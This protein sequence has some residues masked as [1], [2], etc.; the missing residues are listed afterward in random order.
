MD[1]TWVSPVAGHP[2]MRSPRVRGH[3]GQ[4]HGLL[5]SESTSYASAI[6]LNLCSA[7][8]LLSGFLSGCHFNAAF[9]YLHRWAAMNTQQSSGSGPPSNPAES[10]PLTLWAKASKPASC[11]TLPP[12][13]SNRSF[14]AWSCLPNKH[15][16]HD[17]VP[18]AVQP[19]P[20]SA[21]YGAHRF[22]SEPSWA[23]PWA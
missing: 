13:A 3:T 22:A 20:V 9:L 2:R 18:H 8:S 6:S 16:W 1:A 11:R 15:L 21:L 23:P 17:P 12:P 4:H 14:L 10:T 7:Y 5:L 19:V